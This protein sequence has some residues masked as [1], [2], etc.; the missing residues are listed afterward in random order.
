VDILA[1][2]GSSKAAD[3]VIKSHPAP[4]RLKTLLSLDAKNLG[5]VMPDADLDVAVKECVAGST[6]FNGQRCTALKLLMVHTSVVGAF[7]EKFC[8]AVNSLAA[9]TPFGK[10]SITPL[11]SSSTDF[12]KQLV[13]DAEKFGATVV[14]K[15]EGG[16]HW[17]RSIF[18]PAVVHPVTPEM[19]LWN[20]EQFGPVIPV[21]V[22]DSLSEVHDYLGK[23]HFGQQAS[24]FTSQ[25][26]AATPS[27]ELTGLLDACALSTC[28]VNIN[29]QCQ[30]GPDIFPFAGRRSSAMGTI[31]VTEVLRAVSIETM[32]AAK[33]KELIARACEGSSVLGAKAA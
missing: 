27:A 7:N 9:G 31:S 22:Y 3:A 16:G 20:E 25:D 6:S 28:R 21:A 30:R 26:A 8:A 23:T 10:N 15:S 24:I 19:K 2:I 13:M 29:A 11:G 14:N 33:K 5:V 4:H 32:V 18:F 17:D 1:F 12:M